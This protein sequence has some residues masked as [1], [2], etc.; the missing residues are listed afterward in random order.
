[1][2]LSINKFILCGQVGQ[3][4]NLRANDKLCSFQLKITKAIKNNQTG[5]WTY[6]TQWINVVVWGDQAKRLKEK[7]QQYDW[8]YVEGEFE[9]NEYTDNE[10]KEHKT[11]Q[12]N[13]RV[14]LNI[15]EKERSFASRQGGNGGGQSSPPPASG[16]NYDDDIPF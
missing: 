16:P 13:G 7:M 5:E 9:I 8:V 11:P 12:C 6:P 10:G 3:Y 14:M 4:I 2:A 15:T 1:M